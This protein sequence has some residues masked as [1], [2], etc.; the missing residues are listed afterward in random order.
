MTAITRAKALA[1]DYPLL[2]NGAL[3]ALVLAYWGVTVVW[4]SSLSLAHALR[5]VGDANLMT[6]HLGTAA[7]AAMVAGFSGV[8]VVFGLSGENDRF[9]RLRDAGGARLHANWISVV[10]TSFAGAF[11]ALACATIAIGGQPRVSVW[12]GL[13]AMLL[14]AHGAVRLIWLFSAL[15]RVVKGEDGDRK[16]AD[17]TV[18]TRELFP[19]RTR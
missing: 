9:R 13:Y 15:A 17:S 7:L 4:S 2:V 3:L 11:L 8:V 12:I 1:Q 6:L 18:S 19:P 10:A 16:R 14:P 5:S